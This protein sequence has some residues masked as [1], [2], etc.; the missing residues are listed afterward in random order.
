MMNCHDAGGLLDAYIDGELDLVRTLDFENHLSGCTY[1]RAARD[2]YE[3]LRRSVQTHGVYFKAPEGLEQRI[4]IQLRGASAPERKHLIPSLFPRW[5]A[6]AVAASTAALVVVAAVSVAMF[7]RTSRTEMLAQEVVSSHIRSLMANH[8]TDVPSSDQHT[9]K[10][11]FNGKLD[12]APPV[13]D[14]AP[15]GFPLIGGRLDYLDSRP[16]AALLYK[17]RQHTISL[18]VWPASGSDSRLRTLAVR[19]YNVIHWTRSGM[20]YWAISDLNARELTD[21]VHDQEQ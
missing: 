18:F 16:V 3:A 11:W 7:Q 1:C 20:A 4:R 15:E 17:H 14:L 21:F 13:K 8:L 9:V 2:E 5:R 19:G 6:F 10:P 12:F